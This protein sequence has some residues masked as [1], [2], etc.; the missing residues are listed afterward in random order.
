MW[1]PYLGFCSIC[2]QV[3]NQEKPSRILSGYLIKT[4]LLQYIAYLS[5]IIF[6]KH[7]VY[8]L[9]FGESIVPGG[10]D[11]DLCGCYA[12]PFLAQLESS[13]SSN[14]PALN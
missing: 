13:A 10:Q 8:C 14:Y 2:S 1:P 4:H 7:V 6:H 9:H 11:L 12:A 3:D 5:F